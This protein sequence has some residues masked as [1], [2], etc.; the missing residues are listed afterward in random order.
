MAR[1]TRKDVEGVFALLCKAMG[2]E[3]AT[4]YGQ[5][6]AWFLDYAACYGGYVVGEYDGPGQGRPLGHRR[7][8]AR[9]FVEAVYLALDV[10]D[11]ATGWRS[12]PHTEEN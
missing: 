6:G 1:Y 9:E 12:R 7:R 4:E 8:S 10:L 5:Q 3:V 11:Q 2:K